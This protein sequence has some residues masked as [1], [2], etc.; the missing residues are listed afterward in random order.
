VTKQRPRPVGTDVLVSKAVAAG[1]MA[2][3]LVIDLRHGHL[4]VGGV[5]TG[6]EIGNNSDYGTLERVFEGRVRDRDVLVD[7]GCGSGRVLATWLH[8]YPA[9]RVVGIE[10]EERV[11]RQTA[12]RFAK[13]PR[14]TVLRGDAVN[15]IPGDATLLYLFNPF[16]R[17]TMVRLRDRLV[18]RPPTDPPL[19]L[20]Y[21]NP[22]FVDVFDDP[23]DWQVRF[24][25]IGPNPR[26]DDRGLAV[27]DRRFSGPRLVD[28]RDTEGTRPR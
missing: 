20:L 25:P 18:R 16:D 3:N 22:R 10:I 26:P 13:E 15:A 17:A 27:V 1:R 9:Q 12:R 7:V 14:C 23:D 6:S 24:E 11:A 4:M 2:R 8:R 19:R 21:L 28:L 5:V